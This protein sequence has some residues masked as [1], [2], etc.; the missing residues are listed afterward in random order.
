MSPAGVVYALLAYGTWGLIPAYWKLL[1]SVPVTEILA[2]RAVGTVVFSVA[3]LFVLRRL[4]EVRDALR[5][6]RERR[7]LAAG[8]VLI[9]INWGVFVWAV[10]VGRIVE[11]SLGYYLNPIV[12]VLLGM[13]LLREH[14]SR[15][16]GI[17]VVLAA[18]G[19]VVMLVSHGKLPWIS[20]VLATSF[21]LYGLMHK[22]TNVRPIPALAVETGG[23]APLAVGFLVVAVEPAGGALGTA[24]PLV[25]TLLLVAGPATALPLLWFASAARRLPL[26]TLGLFQYLAPTLSLLLAV[27]AY[28]EP[29]TRTH[30]VAFALIWTAL[31]LY[32]VDALYASRS[33]GLRSS[34]TH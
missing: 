34:T 22:L 20:L 6:T 21:G 15:A 24:T 7:A 25:K 23:L 9:A 11:T 10:G 27:F 1:V 17:A 4:P 31:A 28:G 33:S 16:Q 29:F 3:L 2:H 30:G 18:C 26:S 13:L 32:S 14:L 12:N 8:G 19:V 5:S